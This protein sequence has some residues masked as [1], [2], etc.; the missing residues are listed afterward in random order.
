[1]TD[2]AVLEAK[3]L[4]KTF[5]SE[6]ETVHVFKGIDF[7]LFPGERVAITGAS[8]SGKTTLLHCLAGL[9]IAT[10]GQVC[11]GEQEISAQSEQV[12]G[13]LR[14]RYLGFVFQFHH[15]INELSAEE[16]V[17]LPALMQGLKRQE[18]MTRARALL[19][20]VG[21]SH[22]LDHRPGT[23]SGGERQ[24]VALVRAL[25]NRP[26]FVLADE[27]TGNLDQQTAQSVQAL[28]LELSRE[29]QTAFLIVTHDHR[30]AE[31][32]DRSLRLTSEG[33]SAESES[34]MPGSDPGVD[35]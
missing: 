30:F 4:T 8:G 33:L 16:N 24:R 26:T 10:S 5:Q 11:W 14:N 32:S 7:V 35:A 27:P 17:A 34:L 2:A 3:Q 18:A 6:N 20:R 23:L 22:R 19:E 15:L 9:E 25:V 1:M 21:L 12:R 29:Y 28:L 31:S 13:E